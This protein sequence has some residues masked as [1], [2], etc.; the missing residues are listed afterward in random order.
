MR[1]KEIN[2]KIPVLQEAGVYPKFNITHHYLN[3]DFGPEAISEASK[4][5]KV[6]KNRIMIGSIHHFHDFE[7]SD[8]GGVRIIF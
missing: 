8:L 2:E 1:Y 6:R 3:L 7:Y 5:F 4:E